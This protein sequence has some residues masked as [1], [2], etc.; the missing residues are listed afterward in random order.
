[1]KLREGD[2][3]IRMHGEDVTLLHD[4]LMTLGFSIPDKGIADGVFG[5]GTEQV[6]K[7]F[8]EK[9][10]LQMSG[11]VDQETAARINRER[12]GPGQDSAESLV[13]NGR[14]VYT[15]GKP[16]ADSLVHAFDKDL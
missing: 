7:E 5:Q 1:M 4:E 16:L 6:V 15:D 14:V 9:Y 13:V 3:R 12:Q 8:Q 2:L 10:G 11:I